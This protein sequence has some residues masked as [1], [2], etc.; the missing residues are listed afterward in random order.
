M[1]QF[2]ALAP[3][4]QINGGSILSIINA[5]GVFKRSADN[6]LEQRGLVNLTADQW[7]PQQ[8]WLDAFKEICA[9]LGS[10]SLKQIGGNI[11]NTAQFPPGLD[12][13]EKA[14]GALDAGYHM[15]HRGG[16]IGH[17]KFVSTGP[18]SANVICDT[19]YPCDFERGIIDTMAMKYKPAGAIVRVSHDTSQPC[20]ISGGSSCTYTVQW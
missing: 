8:I 20:R 10:S 12:T 4:V 18:R 15:S 16:L 6:I 9:K 13:I 3:G 14:L 2:V 1:A 11:P 5:M 17:Y 7:Y 19:P